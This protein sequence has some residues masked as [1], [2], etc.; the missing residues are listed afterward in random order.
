VPALVGGRRRVRRRLQLGAR[1][2]RDV[3]E[4]GRQSWRPNGRRF[5]PG[6]IVV[7]L[8]HG[9]SPQDVGLTRSNLVCSNELL[10]V[11]D[12]LAAMRAGREVRR[13]D[14]PRREGI[15]ERAQPAVFEVWDG[16]RFSSVTRT[17]P[18][19][20][21]GLRQMQHRV[22]EFAGSRER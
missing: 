6:S 2:L 18:R 16:I 19:N 10:G 5:A 15:T 9:V 4:I 11:I 13:R 21:A 17:R 12:Q 20:R 1:I 14:Q 3:G 22:T 7:W 8:G